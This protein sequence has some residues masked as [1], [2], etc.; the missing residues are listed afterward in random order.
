[1][2]IQETF[3]EVRKTWIGFTILFAFFGSISFFKGTWWYPYL[4]SASAFFAFFAAVAPMAL[5][6]LFRL[7]VRFAMFLGWLNTRLI[8]GLVFY[9][10]ITPLGLIIRLAGTDLLDE[11]IDKKAESYWKKRPPAPGPARYEKSY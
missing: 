6:P 2:A 3:T 7:W 4:Y 1:M 11:K 10:M 9:L 5:L 8:L